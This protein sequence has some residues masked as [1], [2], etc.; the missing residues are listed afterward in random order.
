MMS[1]KAWVGY[2]L[3]ECGWV[4]DVADARKVKAVAPLACKAGKVD[5]R[6]RANLARQTG[7]TNPAT[8][9]EPA[10]R[11]AAL[12]HPDRPAARAGRVLLPA[13]AGVPARGSADFWNG[14]DAGVRLQP[15]HVPAPA[16]MQAPSR[17]KRFMELDGARLPRVSPRSG[18]SGKW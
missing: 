14:R 3:A 13:A 15:Q 18:L 16:W 6:V 4:T 7:L 12:A 9:S 1:G 8:R 2:R 5:G 11:R 17:R 10:P